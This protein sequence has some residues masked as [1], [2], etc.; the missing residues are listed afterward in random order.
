MSGRKRLC[1]LFLAAI[2]CLSGCGSLNFTS[3]EPPEIV[4]FDGSTIGDRTPTCTANPALAEQ[5]R[6]AIM[7]QRD[8]TVRGWELDTVTACLD[9]LMALP[10]YFWFRGYHVQATTGL[11]TEAEISFTWLY[12]DGPAKYV[13]MCRKADE[14]LAGAPWAGD[15]SVAL[16]VHDWL[17]THVTYADVEG[18][19]QTAYAAICEGSAVCGGIA[20][21]FAF[22]LNRAGI[23]ACTVTGS[24]V[25]EGETLTHAWNF[26][27]LDGAVYAF[28]LT[29][30]N[31]D[32]YDAYG[33]EY[34][35]HSWFAVTSRELNTAHTAERP[36]DEIAAVSNADNYFIRQSALVTDDSVNAVVAAFEPQLAAGSNTLTLRCADRTVYD[37]LCFR[38]FELQEISPVLKR[39]GV[40]SGGSY[41][42]TYT[43]QDDLFIITLYL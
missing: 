13:S 30:D 22:L 42:L 39:L 33:G 18:Y 17:A 26:A 37:A 15:Y 28:D 32:R 1:I 7:E 16:Y 19:D 12:D 29:W 41:E 11:R 5:L 24:A 35:C 6:A 14:I 2:V 31:T 9:E 25:Q 4:S 10:D 3:A 23:P 43:Q 34:V 27:E 36:Q 8:A 38:L 20:D 40:Y 21:A